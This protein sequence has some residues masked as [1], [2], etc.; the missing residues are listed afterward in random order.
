M[1]SFGWLNVCERDSV[2]M[3]ERDQERERE[4]HVNVLVYVCVGHRF[5]CN[6]VCLSV[7]LACV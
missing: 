6:A 3:G 1:G 4:L 5:I 7:C 2:L